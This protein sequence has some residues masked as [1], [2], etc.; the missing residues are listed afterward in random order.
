MPNKLL[1]NASNYVFD[2]NVKQQHAKTVKSFQR[3][4]NKRKMRELTRKLLLT[5]LDIIYLVLLPTKQLI[6][7]FL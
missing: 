6:L 4:K 3:L 5:F 7:I 2:V 1:V